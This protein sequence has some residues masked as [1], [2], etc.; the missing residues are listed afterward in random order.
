MIMSSLSS[1]IA[2][3]HTQYKVCILPFAQTFCATIEISLHQLT[4]EKS[5]ILETAKSLNM[6]G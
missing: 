4:L 6:G 2:Q 3:W 5:C 1:F